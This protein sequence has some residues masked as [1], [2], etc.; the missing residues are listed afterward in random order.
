MNF[1]LLHFKCSWVL[2][3]FL[4]RVFWSFSLLYFSIFFI[5]FN[6]Q[7][8]SSVHRVLDKNYESNSFSCHERKVFSSMQIKQKKKES[9]FLLPNMGITCTDIGKKNG[10]FELQ[11]FNQCYL[12]V[13]HTI[14]INFAHRD[15][16]C[17]KMQTRKQKQEF[18][19]WNS[20]RWSRNSD[21]NIA[22]YHISLEPV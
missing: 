18:E 3:T 12:I 6:Y 21:K 20:F 19:N 11:I 8:Y 5:F 9:K 13:A 10:A 2:L 17:S 15:N 22:H 4:L 7:Q 16:L 14:N 1:C